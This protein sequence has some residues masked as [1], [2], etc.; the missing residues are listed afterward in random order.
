MKKKKGLIILVVILALFIGL[1]FVLDSGILEKKQDDSANNQNNIPVIDLAI[2]NWSSPAVSIAI[3][4]A[5][6]RY[7][8]DHMTSP[9]WQCLENKK[10]PLDNAKMD[11]MAAILG[12]MTATRRLV[13]NNDNMELFGLN[14][15]V[16]K[17]AFSSATGMS[18]QLKIGIQNPTTT[19]YYVYLDGS[20]AIFMMA[21]SYVDYF[22]NDLLAYVIVPEFPELVAS[23]ITYA[24]YTSEGINFKASKLSSANT[25][26]SGL[27]TGVNSM[28]LSKVET[29]YTEDLAKYGF[30]APFITAT[31][32]YEKTE[33]GLSTGKKE[34]TLKVG[35]QDPNDE[36]YYYATIS[37]Y[38]NTV[39]RLY[40]LSLEHLTEAA[41]NLPK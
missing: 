13:K 28:Y 38:P 2:T 10:Y 35:A 7:T 34:F 39:Y 32:K 30:D 8:Y 12:K 15:P 4:N 22:L 3:D 20:D 17:V 37:D 1:Y 21:S 33:G 19:D 29:P 18:A 24:E 36:N 9:S 26:H 11:E 27:L 14:N 31:F 16:A 41:N 6:G 23:E 25:A 5:S 40:Y